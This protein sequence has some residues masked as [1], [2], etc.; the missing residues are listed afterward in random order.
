MHLVIEIHKSLIALFSSIRRLSPFVPRSIDENG[1]L[2]R[3]V[4]HD[5]SMTFC[6]VKCL[7]DL[8]R[9]KHVFDAE[10]LYFNKYNHNLTECLRRYYIYIFIRILF[11][12]SLWHSQIIAL[13]KYCFVCCMDEAMV[14]LS[15][16]IDQ[17]EDI[18]Y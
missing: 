16:H 18:G 17:R 9:E 12:I 5:H 10:F 4:F 3:F 2:R 11:I 14:F 6:I 13:S 7:W 15:K 1:S 8:D